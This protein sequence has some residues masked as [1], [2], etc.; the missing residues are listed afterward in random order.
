MRRI[1][2]VYTNWIR[3]CGWC[4]RRA[5]VATDGRNLFCSYCKH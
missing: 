4:G 5:P 2:H 1:T 3:K